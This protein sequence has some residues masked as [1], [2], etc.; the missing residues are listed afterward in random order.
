MSSL[1]LKNL[2]EAWPGQQ[3]CSP[4]STWR[5][6]VAL[7]WVGTMGLS[8]SKFRCC[9]HALIT[10]TV[11]F[12]MYGASWLL[13]HELISM[14]RLNSFGFIYCGVFYCD[15]AID[16][17]CG[18]RNSPN[19]SPNQSESRRNT[20]AF[21]RPG[22]LVDAS[23]PLQGLESLTHLNTYTGRC[24]CTKRHLKKKSQN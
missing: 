7:D 23:S 4:S 6:E 10:V 21:I 5:V 20:S 3:Q 1:N 12:T 17:Q 2:E 18:S 8:P 13:C 9:S 14:L 16:N 15:V 22:F 24:A 11:A 19:L